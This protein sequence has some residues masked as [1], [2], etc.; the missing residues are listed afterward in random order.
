M[1]AIL[2]LIKSPYLNKK[3]FDFDQIWYTTAHLQLNDSHV[4]KY[5]IFKIQ[6]GRWPPFKKLFLSITQQ[7]IS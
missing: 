7:P 5:K 1:A 4:T 6:D 2:Q 3:I